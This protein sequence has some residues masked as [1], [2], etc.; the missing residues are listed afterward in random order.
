M[1]TAFL[2]HVE[3]E[4]QTYK[5]ETFHLGGQKTNGVKSFNICGKIYKIKFI[6]FSSDANQMEINVN[7]LS[8]VL[9]SSYLHQGNFNSIILHQFVKKYCFLEA[10]NPSKFYVRLRTKNS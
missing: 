8:H 10:S 2:T 5:K 7:I 6:S 9:T 4:N 1:D 3:Y